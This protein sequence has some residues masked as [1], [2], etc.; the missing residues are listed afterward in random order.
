MATRQHVQAEISG[1]G[2]AHETWFEAME[3]WSANQQG[4]ARIDVSST[5]CASREP[6]SA[7]A[8]WCSAQSFALS[9]YGTVMLSLVSV[10]CVESYV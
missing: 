7:A 4:A 6:C 1:P 9:V 5:L 10:F 3:E 8:L 2:L